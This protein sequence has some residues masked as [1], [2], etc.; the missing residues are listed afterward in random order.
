[1]KNPLAKFFH[2]NRRKP[3]EKDV[4][5]DWPHHYIIHHM[6]Y[7]YPDATTSSGDYPSTSETDFEEALTATRETLSRLDVSVDSGDIFQPLGQ[8][9]EIELLCNLT[10]THLY[11]LRDC[12][13]IRTDVEMELHATERHIDRIKDAITALESEKSKLLNL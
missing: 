1:M 4:T 13:R 11:H 7:A 3:K 12:I 8:N 9:R 6:L 10:E 2:R 5:I